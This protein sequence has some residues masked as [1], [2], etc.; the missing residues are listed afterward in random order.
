MTTNKVTILCTGELSAALVQKAAQHGITLQVVP[1]ITIQPVAANLLQEQVTPLLTQPHTVVF[2]SAHAVQAVA[3]CLN[4]HQPDWK[5][6]CISPATSREVE[7]VFGQRAITATAP[8]GA[9]LAEMLIA[10]A[11]ADEIIFFCGD[12]RR[13][14]LPQQV[15]NA[16]LQLTEIVS[17]QTVRTPQK[18]EGSY[19]RMVFLS[20]SAVQSYF[21]QNTIQPHTVLFSIGPT[22]TATLQSFSGNRIVECETP[23]RAQLI[24]SVINHFAKSESE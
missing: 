16:G 9:Q 15:R 2:T 11:R 20:P 19:D 22:T 24:N 5:I 21:S 1:F 17:Y 10:D 3:G 14:E 7:S 23:E 6:F 18:I 12:Q 4:G 13:E 8:T